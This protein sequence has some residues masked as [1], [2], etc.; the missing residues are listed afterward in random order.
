MKNKQ[1]LEVKKEHIVVPGH[2]GT[3]Y[4]LS[5]EVHWNKNMYLLEHETYG[6]D[7][8]ALIVDG[9]LNVVLSDVYNGWSDME[10]FMAIAEEEIN[11]YE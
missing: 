6:E 7:V 10:E 8:A 4:V 9:D 2:R 1:N 3:W 5:E 11:R